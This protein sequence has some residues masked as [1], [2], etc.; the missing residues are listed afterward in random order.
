M[1]RKIQDLGR[2]YQGNGS[3]NGAGARMLRKISSHIFPS[4]LKYSFNGAG[5]R[6]LRKIEQ[7]ADAEFRVRQASM[8]PERECSGK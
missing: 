6:M 1:L 8:V 2:V 7:A 3:F 4:L 5:A